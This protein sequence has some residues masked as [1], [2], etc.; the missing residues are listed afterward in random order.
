MHRIACLPGDDSNDDI[1]FV[2]QPNAEVLFLS[3]A[4][5]DITILGSVIKYKE[6]KYWDNRIR[7]LPIATIMHPAQIDHYLRTTGDKA[8]IIIVRLLGGRGHWSYGLEQ[9]ELWSKIKNGRKLIVIAGTKEFALELN[10]ISNINLKLVNKLSELLRIGGVYN[11]MTF[12]KQIKLLLEDNVNN[13]FFDIIE[14]DNP[15]KWDWKEE[16]GAR[17]GI[18]LYKALYQSNDIDYAKEICRLLR[19]KSLCPRL[20]WLDTLRNE[21]TQDTIIK[22]FKEE[23]VEAILTSTS[24]ASLSFED[25]GT[26]NTIWDKLNVP[27]YQMLTSNKS[28]FNWE[29]NPLGLDSQDL[30]LQIVLPELD[31]RITTRICGFKEIEDDNSALCTAIN[32]LTP[33]KDGIKWVVDHIYNNISL[34]SK[35]PKLLKV[36]IVLANYPIRNSRI[37]N[38]VGLDTPAS[39][40]LLIKWLI[41]YGLDIKDTSIPNNAL[42]LMNLLLSGRTNSVESNNNSPLDYLSYENYIKWW[43]KLSIKAKAPIEKKWSVPSKAID[44]EENGFA[45]HGINFGNLNILI[46]P[47][48]GYEL[49]DMDQM[50]SPDLPP[51]HRYLAQYLWMNNSFNNDVI[52]HLG[53]HGSLEWLPGKGVGLSSDCYPNIA[54]GKVPNIY[55]FIVNDPGEGSQAKRRTNA[56]II[57]HL[58]PPLARA[59]LYGG[60][61]ELEALLDEYYESRM[62]SSKRVDIIKT[63]IIECFAKNKIRISKN[64]VISNIESGFEEIV[65]KAESYLCEIKDTQIR[66][67]L[68]I[69]GKEPSSKNLLELLLSICRAPSSNYV[70][71]TQWI[72]KSFGL[73]FDPWSQYPDEGITKKDM[74]LIEK[75]S[76]LKDSQKSHY[77]DWIEDQ[78]K[79]LLSK[80]VLKLNPSILELK[81][82]TLNKS[83][84]NLFIDDKNKAYFDYIYSI[85]KNLKDSNKKEKINFMKAIKGFRVPSGPSGAPTRGRPEVLPTGNNFYSVD[86][87]G[88]PTEAAFELGRKTSEQIIDSHMQN[89]GEHLKSLALSV[90][91]TATMRN[92]G[93]EIAQL[94]ALIGV[95]PIW[96]GPT[97]RVIDLEVIPLDILG[98]PRVDVIL[99]VSG[100]FRDA[101]PNL[102]SLVNRAQFLLGNLQEANILNPYVAYKKKG[103]STC[104]VY[105]SAPGSYGAGL[106]A[107]IDSGMWESKE[108]L[109][110]SYIEWSKWKYESPAEP[111]EDKEGFI[112]C[113]SNVEVVMHSQ[114]NREHDIL[115][116]DDYYQFHGGLAASVEKITQKKPTILFGDNSRR[117]RP[118][119]KNLEEEIDKVMR[120]RV[121]NPKWLDS[122]KQHGYKGAFEMSA[123]L[124]YMFGY[125]ATTESIPDWAY[126]GIYKEWIKNLN[127][128]EFLIKNNPWAVR[129]ICERLLEAYNRN[130]W[131]NVDSEIIKN[132]KLV[133]NNTDT[134]LELK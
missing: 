37:A 32:R 66:N 53:K 122:M 126:E 83:L 57:D 38:G 49:G 48:R 3:S 80:Y 82:Q 6:N 127:T 120:S 100:L 129:D 26:A 17:V 36:S 109:A 134:K 11:I 29:K 4:N 102:I 14:S 55:P 35:D 124:D 121:L 43:N 125:D 71:L 68:H 33:N 105:G 75:L 42:G 47:S 104:R 54:L 92:G 78:A 77:L 118:I 41:E 20:L 16:D 108:D 74:K 2:E 130:L 86:L 7:A 67:G 119:I 111:V 56:V 79:L 96:D 72:S 101:F 99:R 84:G 89:T 50:H 107:L 70:G 13:Q 58:T 94:L 98:R 115:D 93:E 28:K 40:F 113:L 44:L 132:I 131:I 45:I 18:I 97:R 23:Q 90:W 73:D 123:T 51:P 19:K 116:S 133:Y 95:R 63:K 64:T 117:E 85:Y 21:E 22:I 25:S 81:G 39:L 10:S 112:E 128:R 91:G 106:Q 27:V 15:M 88:L 1:S 24:F 31:G 114:D 76:S 12:L 52:V 62:L 87:R 59:G 60:L 46:Q 30:S 9:L 65:S 103:L 8:K 69:F 5:T 61:A 110:A 34:R